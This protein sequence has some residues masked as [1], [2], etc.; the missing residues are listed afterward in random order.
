VIPRR[1][2]VLVA[3]PLLGVVVMVGWW[4][5]ARPGPGGAAPASPLAASLL[6]V[7]EP[8]L[9]YPRRRAPEELVGEERAAWR[10]AHLDG[11]KWRIGQCLERQVPGDRAPVLF[12]ASD[13]ARAAG[14][15]A[16]WQAAHE[17]IAELTRALGVDGAATFAR[18]RAKAAPALYDPAR[19]VPP[20]PEPAR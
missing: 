1:A 3:Y 13:R 16:G 5:L 7:G 18:A 10:S 19:A 14:F 11:W 20:P 4:W 15:T 8:S 6:G 9:E 17:Q 12:P 2:L